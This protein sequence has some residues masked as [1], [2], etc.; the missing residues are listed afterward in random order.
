[1]RTRPR[2]PHDAHPQHTSDQR[3]TVPSHPLHV[4]VRNPM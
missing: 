1:M 3:Q 4:S 2:L